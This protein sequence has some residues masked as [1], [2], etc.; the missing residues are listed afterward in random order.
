MAELYFVKRGEKISGP[1][2]LEQLQKL[3]AQKKLKSN[4]LVGAS[5]DGEWTRLADVYKD[6]ASGCFSLST[7]PD[8]ASDRE[9]R[10]TV[11]QLDVM[12]FLVEGA[13]YSEL[14]AAIR[15]ASSLEH[16]I[17]GA[18][19]ASGKIRGEGF[20]GFT[21]LVTVQ[22]REDGAIVLID[23]DTQAGPLNFEAWFD[24]TS[25][26]GWALF[27]G[28]QLFNATVND[29]AQTT[30]QNDVRQLIKNIFRCIG[31][32]DLVHDIEQ[33]EERELKEREEARKAM[34]EAVDSFDPNARRIWY[35]FTH[36]PKIPLLGVFFFFF[37]GLGM[38]GASGE[39]S[40]K[41][42]TGAVLIFMFGCLLLAASVYIY[43]RYVSPISA[44]FTRLRDQEQ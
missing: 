5:K 37:W 32:T 13:V 1:F 39:V 20:S 31:C 38:F 17:T 27:A 22:S 35:V 34:R 15:D 7:V 29:A 36:T 8:N 6:I 14:F 19:E 26:G 21:F 16:T 3:L 30:I 18:F 40:E 10:W 33:D 25:V 9:E 23:G 24:P 4:D 11:K 28:T 43:R 41:S 12:E 42:A 2:G 44:D